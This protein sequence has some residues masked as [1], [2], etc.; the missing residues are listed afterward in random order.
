MELPPGAHI[1]W[2]NAE[3]R[4]HLYLP[5][6]LSRWVRRAY[7]YFGHVKRI[8]VIANTRTPLLMQVIVKIPY[9]RHG[10]RKPSYIFG[11]MDTYSSNFTPRLREASSGFN[12]RL[13]DMVVGL[14]LKRNRKFTPARISHRGILLTSRIGV[15]F[16][17]IPCV[18]RMR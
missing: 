10:E 5:T 1:S 12:I 9:F 2:A 17:P 16:H 18:T 3:K 7:G 11:R 4:P 13:G 6:Y 14:C 15:N 8:K